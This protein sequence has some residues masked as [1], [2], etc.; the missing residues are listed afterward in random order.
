MRPS[1]LWIIEDM[2]TR[3]GIEFERTDEDDYK[4]D[5]GDVTIDIRGHDGFAQGFT[6]WRFDKDGKLKAVTAGW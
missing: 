4:K 3:A 2:L 1:D 5:P 6:F